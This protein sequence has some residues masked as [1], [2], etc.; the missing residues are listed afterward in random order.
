MKKYKKKYIEWLE[1]QNNK[2]AAIN[3]KKKSK[4]K[5]Y[6]YIKDSNGNI[7]RVK[8]NEKELKAPENFSIINNTEETVLYYL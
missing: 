5:F 2:K 7:H 1:R 6:D 4:K 3:K 8:I